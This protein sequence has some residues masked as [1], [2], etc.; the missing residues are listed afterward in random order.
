MLE[1]Y[2]VEN[3]MKSKE[4]SSKITSTM[5]ERY[6][7]EH[8]LQYDKFLQK[9]QYTCMSNYGVFVPSKS[10]EICNK[11]IKTKIDRYGENFSKIEMEKSKNTNLKKYGRLYGFD[12]EK[13]KQTN[14]ER[15]GVENPMISKCS[16]GEIKF[17]GYSKSSQEFF[18]KI[19]KYL[20]KKYTT[21]YAT[22][23]GEKKITVDNHNYYVDF[24][25]NELKIAIEFNGD[26]WHGN[27]SLFKA[28]DKCFPMDSNITAKDLWEMDNIKRKRLES[29]G[30]KLVVI[31]ESEYKKCKDVK[32]WIK[33][34]LNLDI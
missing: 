12:Y 9:S 1:R 28:D 17:K 2:G 3:P 27:P 25:I 30:I 23:N 10:K 34:K 24:Y 15:Y 4:L 22:K 8:A 21:Q 14:L 11:I 29:M 6:G 18:E 7:V 13:V 31:W 32:H 26:T 20:D 5:L 19:D 16:R 33:D